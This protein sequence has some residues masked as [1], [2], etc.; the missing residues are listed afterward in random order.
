MELEGVLY[1]AKDGIARITIN[2]PEKLN[3]VTFG[4]IKSLLA[5]FEAAEDDA[6]V[7]VVVISGK[8]G[9]AF[10]AG[11][12]IN[13]FSKT[14]PRRALPMVR[15]G[16][17]LASTMRNM[18]KPIIAAI[19]GYAMGFGCELICFCDLAIATEGSSLAITELKV[20]SSGSFGGT[21][22]FPRLMGEKKAREAIFLAKKIEAE[23]AERLGLINKVVPKDKLEE[24]VDNW[25]TRILEM[26][27]QSIRV[28]KTSL[29]FESDLMQPSLTHGLMLW[30]FLN[31]SEEWQE[32]MEAFLEKRKPDF[33]KYRT[34]E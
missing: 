16:L 12:D 27:P 15:T 17:K 25:C 21:Q 20:G 24:E 1:E 14:N 6:S 22:M 33:S 31:G 2:R 26:S 4:V 3:S 29:N 19:D 30:A 34:E 23:E 5:A 10:S 32:G 8:G 13:E 18:G 11:G 28:A 7:G 9:K